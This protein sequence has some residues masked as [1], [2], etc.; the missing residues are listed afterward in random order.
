MW[1]INCFRGEVY[2]KDG[3]YLGRGGFG[4][5]NWKKVLVENIVP[6]LSGILDTH[7]IISNRFDILNR[8]KKRLSTRLD[9]L[10]FNHV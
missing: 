8:P 3:E 2:L 1:N 9:I 4:R 10:A 5:R 6:C 7:T